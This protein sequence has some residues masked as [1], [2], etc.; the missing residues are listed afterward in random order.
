MTVKRCLF[1]IIVL[2]ITSGA[3]LSRLC[4][5]HHSAAG[6]GAADVTIRSLIG[7]GDGIT[8]PA[9]RFDL[10]KLSFPRRSSS[11][12]PKYPNEYEP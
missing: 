9:A 8:L 10:I 6:G 12:Y 11:I 1:N 7:C 3:P 4:Q 5:F 2:P